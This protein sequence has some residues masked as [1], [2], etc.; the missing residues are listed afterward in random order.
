MYIHRVETRIRA[1]TLIK[2]GY[3]SPTGQK[4]I[5]V[6]K[7]TLLISEQGSET[8]AISANQPQFFLGIHRKWAQ[9]LAPKSFGVENTKRVRKAVMHDWFAREKNLKRVTITCDMSTSQIDRVFLTGGP[10]QIQTL[11]HIRADR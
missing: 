6:T 2:E 7:W 11:V 3:G 9:L 5:R 8:E 1:C 4:L 10:P